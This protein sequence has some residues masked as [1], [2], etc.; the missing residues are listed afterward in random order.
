[1]STKHK[2]DLSKIKR[3]S[4]KDRCSKVELNTF[5]KVGKSDDLFSLIPDI[6]VGKNF[7]NLIQSIIKA[8]KSKK[9]VIFCYGAH[10][11]KCGLS[12]LVIDLIENGWITCVAT[13]GA[14]IIHDFEISFCGHTSEEVADTIED[15]SFG[16]VKETGVFLNN[17]AEVAS[18]KNS[19]LGLSFGELIENSTFKYK[20]YSIGAA[21]YRHK[22]PFCVHVAI[23]T[24]IIYQHP[25]CDGANWGKASYND[26]LKFTEVVSKLG[27][28]GVL[29]NF[30]SAV[31][32]PEVFL[33]AL[34]IARNLGNNVTNFTT[35]NFDMFRMYR[36][37]QNIVKRPTQV[38]G[39]GYDFSGHHEIML[40]LLYYFLKYKKV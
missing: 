24:D 15:G 13:N 5:A 29:L 3:I 26:F 39:Q 23:G 10:L 36:P 14:G 17:V 20:K 33:K 34:S 19:G 21:C 16:M 40:P 1:M 25:E 32:I 4:I 9:P 30:G 11:I 2:I 22:I 7:K 8:K 38:S 12:P 27:G 37:T 28:G 18:D 31:I 35:A 6:L